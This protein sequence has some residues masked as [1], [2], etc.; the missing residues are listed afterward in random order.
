[1][2]N[3][4]TNRKLQLIGQL[5]LKLRHPSTP[6]CWHDDCIL[7]F[8]ILV[9]HPGAGDGARQ[10]RQDSMDT[11]GIKGSDFG[12]PALIDDAAVAALAADVG[13]NNLV[14]VLTAFSDELQRRVP[15]LQGA[16]NAKD[17]A[18]IARETHSIK[19]SA[20]TF[21]AAALGAAARR[22]ND[23]SRV[24]DGAMALLGARE[25]LALMPE[26][27]DA[28]ARLAAQAGEVQQ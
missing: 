2:Q 5:Q 15:V 18:A 20:L 16:L 3:A 17:L 22:A 23:A 21:G 19:G 25:V 4:I 27:R 11:T 26:T 12:A 1:L 13:A 14:T 9:S 7:H 6:K 10:H 28:V 8:R 24:G